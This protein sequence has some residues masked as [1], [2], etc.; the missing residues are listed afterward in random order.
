MKSPSSFISILTSFPNT[1]AV[2]Y[3]PNIS[4]QSLVDQ[5]QLF[6]L[7]VDS[8]YTEKRNL[9]CHVNVDRLKNKQAKFIVKAL[10]AGLK[11]I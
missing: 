8:E 4:V 3:L 5:K 6:E 10:K 2:A 11:S 7:N 1:D 9:W